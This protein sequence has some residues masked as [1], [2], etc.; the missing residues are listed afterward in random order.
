MNSIIILLASSLSEIKYN[1]VVN[2]GVVV[3]FKIFLIIR[4]TVLVKSDFL[5]G[6][7]SHY[8]Q[9]HKLN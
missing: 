5:N 9:T 3:D 2:I 4:R 7:I 6:L 1:C 8:Y